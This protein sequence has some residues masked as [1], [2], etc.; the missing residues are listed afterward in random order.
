MLPDCSLHVPI[1]NPA[2]DQDFDTPEAIADPRLS[3]VEFREHIFQ[4]AMLLQNVYVIHGLGCTT[5]AHDEA[6]MD[7]FSEACREVAHAMHTHF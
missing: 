7:H 6:E 1:F 3:D 5:T 2:A 4:W